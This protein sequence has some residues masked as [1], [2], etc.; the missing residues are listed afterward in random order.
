MPPVI[1]TTGAL[2]AGSLLAPGQIAVAELEG[3]KGTFTPFDAMPSHP[4]ELSI[5]LDLEYKV[6][7]AGRKHETSEQYARRDRFQDVSRRSHHYTGSAE[8]LVDAG[9]ALADE[10]V[11]L[12][13]DR[14]AVR[15][16]DRRRETEP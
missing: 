11:D 1:G 8:F 5:L 10:M 14:G 15:S 13:G 16:L 6:R 7:W 3:F 9:D 2:G 4:K 12:I